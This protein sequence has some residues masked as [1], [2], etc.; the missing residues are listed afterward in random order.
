MKTIVGIFIAKNEPLIY[1]AGVVAGAALLLLNTSCAT[2]L[3]GPVNDYQTTK[4][5]PGEPQREI[6][7]GALIAD[8]ILW[9]PIGVAVDFATGAIYKP[10]PSVKQPVLTREEQKRAW[11]EK[12]A[13]LLAERDSIDAAKWAKREARRARKDS[14][15]AAGGN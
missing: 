15:R 4:P 10:A 14:A 8:F 11:Q 13:R 5:A 7:V 12:R 1:W 3:G 6:R 9:G 2:V